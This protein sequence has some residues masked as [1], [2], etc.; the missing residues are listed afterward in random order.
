MSSNA[1]PGKSYPEN[2]LGDLDPKWLPSLVMSSS[3]ITFHPHEVLG[4]RGV[5]KSTFIKKLLETVKINAKIDIETILKTTFYD[6]TSKIQ[7]IPDRYNKVFIADQP[8]IGGLRVTETDYMTR[9][10]P[11]SIQS[12]LQKVN[13]GKKLRSF[14]FYVHA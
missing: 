2:K 12:K 1:V 8:G 10:G 7:S 14:R 3:K 6:V 9:Y 13:F 4:C 5:G 11:G